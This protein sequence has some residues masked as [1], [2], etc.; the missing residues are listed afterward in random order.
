MPICSNPQCGKVVETFTEFCPHCG[1]QSLSKL[2]K[3]GWTAPATDEIS[4]EAFEKSTLK[5][6]RHIE[7]S[8]SPRKVRKATRHAMGETLGQ[9]IARF[10]SRGK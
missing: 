1:K 3:T 9:K 8:P 4:M 7:K 10:F 5:P 6:P 2:S